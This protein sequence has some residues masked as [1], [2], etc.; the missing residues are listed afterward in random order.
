LIK[1]CS[2]NIGKKGLSKNNIITGKIRGNNKDA[3]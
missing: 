3:V 1:F 2:K